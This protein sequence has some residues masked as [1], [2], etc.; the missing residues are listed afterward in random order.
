MFNRTYELTYQFSH[1]GQDP[2]V[3]LLLHASYS[4]ELQC[5]VF[6]LPLNISMRLKHGQCLQEC[7]AS[8]YIL[9]L[10]KVQLSLI[11]ITVLEE[12][13][14]TTIAG[15]KAITAAPAQDGLTIIIR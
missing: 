2:V 14:T 4:F 13:R 8:R 1:Q 9:P 12:S 5:Y 6:Y 3:V 11:C 7:A 15:N 10:C